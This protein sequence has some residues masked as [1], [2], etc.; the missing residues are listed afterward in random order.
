M[1]TLDEITDIALADCQYGQHHREQFLLWAWLG[2]REYY[3]DQGKSV[4]ITELDLSPS[5]EADL[6]DDFVDWTSVYTQ[7]SNGQKITFVHDRGIA[8]NDT[9]NTSEKKLFSVSEANPT[10]AN[11][12]VSRWGSTGIRFTEGVIHNG[13]GYFRC[14]YARNKLAFNALFTRPDK[15]TL[16]YL[17]NGVEKKGFLLVHEY[18]VGALREYIHWQRKLRN[19]R[20][21]E[22]VKVGAERLYKDEKRK[23]KKRFVKITAKAFFEALNA[24]SRA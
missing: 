14:D 15:I 10:L 9:L 22:S 12:Y 20:L 24:T 19:D 2:W 6:P 18:A 16:E 7:S 8:L 5:M 11:Q 13:T 23:I 17:S 1:K 4:A 21:P 3:M